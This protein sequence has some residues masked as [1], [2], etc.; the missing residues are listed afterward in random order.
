M[1][2]AASAD[3][4]HTGFPSRAEIAQDTLVTNPRKYK[5]TANEPDEKA[6]LPEPRSVKEQIPVISI[7]GK[8]GTFGARWYM[9][10]KAE[11][12]SY[13]LPLASRNA[14]PRVQRCP[15]V[16]DSLI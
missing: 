2:R 4:T 5:I 7:E 6:V 16:L 11:R 14:C 8:S 3:K 1:L 12:S 13:H 10:C 15:D 9:S